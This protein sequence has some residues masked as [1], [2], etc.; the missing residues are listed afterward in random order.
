MKTNFAAT[1]ARGCAF[2]FGL[3]LAGADGVVIKKGQPHGWGD[4][5][6]DVET[7]ADWFDARLLNSETQQTR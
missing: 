3:T 4:I 6:A 5:K 2:A 1:L 7:F